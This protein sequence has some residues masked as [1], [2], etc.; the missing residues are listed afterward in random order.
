[1]TDVDAPSAPDVQPDATPATATAGPQ[2]P[3]GGLAETVGVVAVAA[4]VALVG[5]ALPLAWTGHYVAGILFPAWIAVAAAL[6]WLAGPLRWRPSRPDAALLVAA[7]IVVVSTGLNLSTSASHVGTDRDPGVYT[8]AA[9]WL[10]RSGETSAPGIA[11][12][13]FATVR[14]VRGDTALGYADLA[15]RG[16]EIDLVPSTATASIMAAGELAGGDRL[17]FRMAPLLGL[18]ALAFFAALARIVAGRWFAVVAVAGLAATLSEA[19]IARDT[20]AEIA[21]QAVTMGGLWLLLVALRDG[22]VR[23]AALAGAALGASGAIHFPALV[24]LAALLLAAALEG[25]LGGGDAAGVARVRCYAAASLTAVAVAVGGLLGL[26]HYNPAY[27]KIHRE[28]IVD[29]AALIVVLALVYVAALIARRL[30]RLPSDTGRLR[31]VIGIA[32]G[33]GVALAGAYALLLRPSIERAR[34]TAA[35][36]DSMEGL[37]RA[38][39]VAIEPTRS[40]AEQS[41]WWLWDYLGPVALLLGLA[42][43]AFACVSGTRREQAALRVCVPL[44][45][46]A[47]TVFGI[48]PAAFPDQPWVMRRF[49]P[50]SMPMILIFACWFL[51]WLWLRDGGARRVLRP[52]VVV[53][54]VFVVTLPLLV[55]RPVAEA[56]TNGG[57][58]DA[59]HA[60]CRQLGPDAAVVM[61]R[62]VA[63]G[64]WYPQTIRAFC[65]LPTATWID[66]TGRGLKPLAAA[67][68]T[69][70]RRLYAVA[71]TP[72]AL[73]GIGIP[74]NTISSVAATSPHALELTINKPPS[75]YRNTTTRFTYAPISP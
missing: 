6:A 63:A 13:P 29:F 48:R 60:L 57:A 26:R 55:L 30:G 19:Y 16:Q 61:V 59:V 53:A 70:H 43:L 37:Q 11:G 44:A 69:K 24:V 8:V 64:A 12:T 33:T 74:K 68:A 27:F 72:R 32:A 56:Q 40:Y 18:V 52:L 25:W 35:G 65:G 71:T 7:A 17:L 38:A 23:R 46:I 47:T 62:E 21:T 28:F 36:V 10:A 42:G 15:H 31:R 49:A 1:M 20:F 67:W 41:L 75:H 3:R 66:A 4:L 50:E 58:L 14:G 39:G 9:R 34:V 51:G 54:A 5:V 22:S 45:V 2:P 73:Q